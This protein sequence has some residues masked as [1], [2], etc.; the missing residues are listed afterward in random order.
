MKIFKTCLGL[1]LLFE[2]ICFT[3]YILIE[4][5]HKGIPPYVPLGAGAILG[6]VVITFYLAFLLLS[7]EL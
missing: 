5:A 3:L 1:F 2:A 4:E 6:A 7:G